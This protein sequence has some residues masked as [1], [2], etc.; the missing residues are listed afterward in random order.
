MR[1]AFTAI[2]VAALAALPALGH[3]AI[4]GNNVSFTCSQSLTVNDNSYSCLGDFSVVGTE[5][6]ALL[7]SDSLISLSASGDLLL[8]HLKLA[9]PEIKLS[10]SNGQINV[11][12]DVVLFSRLDAPT[13][14]PAVTLQ[15]GDRTLRPVV[16]T[17][18]GAG[19]ELIVNAGGTIN[20]GGSGGS[21]VISED[22]PNTPVILP[23]AGSGTNTYDSGGTVLVF[24]TPEVP[25]ATVPEPGSLALSAVG[26]GALVALLR[27]RRA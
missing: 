8:S 17:E 12:A 11:A 1:R 22:T 24:T 4:I 13:T 26:L 7:Q 21:I 6:D 5:A 25:A 3:A 19:G 18:A 15:A 2:T 9:A 27:R 16:G 14:P 10:S 20:V 23:V